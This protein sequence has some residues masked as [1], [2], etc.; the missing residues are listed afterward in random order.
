MILGSSEIRQ[1]IKEKNL[2]ENYLEENIE[3][4]GIDLRVGKIFHLKSGAKLT[5][6][7]R[8]LPEVE[9]ANE[10]HFVLKPEHYVLIQTM[11]KVNMPL[12]L[13]AR[14][15][16]RSTIQRSGVYQFHA[17]I[18]PGYSG[19]LTFGMKNL[20]KFNFEFEKGTKVSQI[21]F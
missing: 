21:I 13:C 19:V 10:K 9:E 16:P 6:S 8:I 4:A 17:F 15:L 18:D 5:T 1:L 12:N 20:G 11:E 2:L 3:G 14:M 7:E